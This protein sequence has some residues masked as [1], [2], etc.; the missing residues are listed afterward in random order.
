MSFCP[1]M[2]SQ[3]SCKTSYIKSFSTFNFNNSTGRTEAIT[4]E[5]FVDAMTGVNNNDDSDISFS[6]S[7]FENY[8]INTIFDIINVDSSS[9]RVGCPIV[10]L[11]S[12]FICNIFGSPHN[13]PF[14]FAT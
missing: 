8:A 4:T 2:L 14:L 11:L 3:I 13:F 5:V 7:A 9:L 12:I 1:Q 6:S 10:V